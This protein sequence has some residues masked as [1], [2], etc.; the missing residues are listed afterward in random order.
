[1]SRLETWSISS[2]LHIREYPQFRPKVSRLS[3]YLHEYTP[4]V[5]VRRL[6]TSQAVLYDL[7]ILL[8]RLIASAYLGPQNSFLMSV[9]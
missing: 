5:S 9:A 4:I 7:L 2:A 3:L 1:M 8:F 6:Q